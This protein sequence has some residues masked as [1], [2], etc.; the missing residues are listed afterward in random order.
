[1]G[2]RQ[3]VRPVFHFFLEKVAASPA[4]SVPLPKE[5]PHLGYFILHCPIRRLFKGPGRAVSAQGSLAQ[6]AS[7]ISCL[8]SFARGGGGGRRE[9]ASGF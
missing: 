5:L 3:A 8:F 9:R 7:L 6:K 2:Y 1:M 4:L